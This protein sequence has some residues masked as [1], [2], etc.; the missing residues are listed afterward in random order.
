MLVSA[1]AYGWHAH[2]VGAG[3]PVSWHFDRAVF[4]AVMFGSIP[5]SVL[6]MLPLRLLL[7]RGRGRLVWIVSPA[8]SFTHQSDAPVETVLERARTRLEQLGFTCEAVDGTAGSTR[9][10]FHKPKAPK[11]VKFTDHAF[12]GGLTLRPD[13]A[14]TQAEATIVFEDTIVVETGESD[15]MLALARYLVGAED[16]LKA[17]T[18]PFTLACGVVIAVVTALLRPVP[19]LEPWMSS[20]ALSLSLASVGM[21][22]FGGYPILKNRAENY[23]LGLAAVGLLAAVLPLVA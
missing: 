8:R 11:V 5:A 19:A 16:E 12:S 17:A 18:I 21:I 13:G 7:S 2:L 20:Q 23:G 4:V 22:L 9:L 15:R 3:F 6:L 10:V 1:G 14:A